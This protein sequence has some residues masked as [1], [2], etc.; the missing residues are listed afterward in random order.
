MSTGEK[1][2]VRNLEEYVQNMNKT[3]S[4]LQSNV[5][6]LSNTEIA[7]LIEENKICKMMFNKVFSL[8]VTEQ[9]RRLN[10]EPAIEASE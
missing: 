9:V 6:Q 8:L 3:I 5:E 10:L 7:A 4:E 1:L 2:P